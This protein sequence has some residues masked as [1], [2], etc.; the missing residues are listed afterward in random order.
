MRSS[1]RQPRVRKRPPSILE[2]QRR[3]DRTNSIATEV[4]LGSP[5]KHPAFMVDWARRFVERRAEEAKQ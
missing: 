3:Y 5:E 4:I 1:T 2:Q